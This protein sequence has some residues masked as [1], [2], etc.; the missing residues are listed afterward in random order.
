MEK[1]SN[2]KDNKAKRV[3][4]R[5]FDEVDQYITQLKVNGKM[6]NAEEIFNLVK[7]KY[8]RKLSDQ[9]IRNLI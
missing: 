1:L 2:N 5:T 3:S 9:Q 8:G 4:P 6:T 7:N